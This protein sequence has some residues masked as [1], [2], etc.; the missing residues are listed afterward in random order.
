MLDEVTSKGSKILHLGCVLGTYDEPE[1]MPVIT[2]AFGECT[3]IGVIRNG[4]EHPGRRAV[5]GDALSSEIREM[6]PNRT[7]STEA[8]SDDAGLYD[9]PAR[10]ITVQPSLCGAPSGHAAAAA[11]REGMPGRGSCGPVRADMA[12]QLSRGEDLRDEQLCGP[13]SARS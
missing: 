6:S 9:H 5:P 3:Q 13:L 8:L 7:G 12:C 11:A 1:M 10:T 4:V 2:G